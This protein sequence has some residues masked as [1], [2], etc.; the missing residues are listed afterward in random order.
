LSCVT[1]KSWPTISAHGSMVGSAMTVT[2]DA[3]KASSPERRSA[4]TVRSPGPPVG[5]RSTKRSWRGVTLA[6]EHSHRPSEPKLRRA[7]PFCHLHAE[8]FRCQSAGSL[9]AQPPGGPPLRS[10][11]EP[12][13]ETDGRT[14]SSRNVPCESLPSGCPSAEAS[15]LLPFTFRLDRCGRGTLRQPAAY[16]NRRTRDPQGYPRTFF[17]VP[18]CTTFIHWMTTGK[19][20]ATCAARQL[21]DRQRAVSFDG[22]AAAD[23]VS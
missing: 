23:Q 9:V 7:M 12:L 8:A 10:A 19:P 3:Q 14:S 18:T 4:E 20:Q 17:V 2:V 21:I 22:V 15:G 16:V 1:A 6:S 5:A 13:F 11:R